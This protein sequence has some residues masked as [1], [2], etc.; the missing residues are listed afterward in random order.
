[1]TIYFLLLNSELCESDKN[2]V[3][4]PEF[5]KNILQATQNKRSFKL[6]ADV[7]LYLSSENENMSNF[8]CELLIEVVSQFG[9][10][11]AKIGIYVML[12]VLGSDDQFSEKRVYV[13]I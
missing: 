8:V 10:T 4:S 13:Y 2:F 7:F 11:Y 9:E 3:F 6:C 12:Q 5:L 1:M